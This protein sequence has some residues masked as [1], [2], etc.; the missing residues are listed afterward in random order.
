MAQENHKRAGTPSRSTRRVDRSSTVV[1]FLLGAFVVIVLSY[2]LPDPQG[3]T[4]PGMSNSAEVQLPPARGPLP[5]QPI[6]A[7]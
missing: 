7:R 2:G 3:E 6:P 1:T 4:D 5:S